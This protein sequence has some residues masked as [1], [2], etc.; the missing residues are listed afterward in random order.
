MIGSIQASYTR[1]LL[2]IDHYRL[3]YL[4]DFSTRGGFLVSI[5]SSIYNITMAE[6]NLTAGVSNLE[7]LMQYMA[8]TQR[9]LSSNQQLL[10]TIV[11]QQVEKIQ[12]LRQML[13]CHDETIG[14][15]QGQIRVL[16]ARLLGNT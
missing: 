8:E 16:L 4:S 11:Q 2:H 1:R 13:Q 10:T 3:F 6:E 15:I 12:L 14:V 9:E 5:I 7:T